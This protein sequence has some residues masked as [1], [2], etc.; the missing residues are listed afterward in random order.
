MKKIA[1]EI[2]TL[3]AE[4]RRAKEAKEGKD[5]AKML[6]CMRSTAHARR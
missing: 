4:L 1:V 6:E 3:E 2:A 5:D